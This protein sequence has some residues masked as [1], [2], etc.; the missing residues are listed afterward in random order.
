MN[1]SG[2]LVLGLVGQEQH[3]LAQPQHAAGEQ[4]E[5]QAEHVGPARPRGHQRGHVG[6]DGESQGQDQVDGWTAQINLRLPNFLY[7]GVFLVAMA[8]S[9]SPALVIWTGIASIAAWSAGFLWVAT[10][11]DSVVS[12]SRDALDSGLS[13]ESVISSFLDPRRVS[14]PNW[15]NQIVFLVL[16]TLIL[17]LTVWRSRRLVFQWYRRRPTWRAPDIRSS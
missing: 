1:G 2:I 3:H 7:L 17:A 6:Q 8:L 11:P 15:T 5:A 4:H 14:L 12:S 10:L 9:Y 16:V 13:A